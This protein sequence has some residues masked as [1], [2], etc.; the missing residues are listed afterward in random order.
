MGEFVRC[1]PEEIQ[2]YSCERI[3]GFYR[4]YTNTMVEEKE[5]KLR[6]NPDL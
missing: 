6:N 3:T 5:H 4:Q 2:K 1:T